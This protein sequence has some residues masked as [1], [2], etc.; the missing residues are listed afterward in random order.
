GRVAVLGD[1]HDEL[2][3]LGRAA[4]Q[5]PGDLQPP[6]ADY[7]CL[8][9]Q[10]PRPARMLPAAEDFGHHQAMPKVAC[11]TSSGLRPQPWMSDA[12]L[13]MTQPGTPR[14]GSLTCSIVSPRMGV[15]S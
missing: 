11:S 7:G 10:I 3:A 1:L 6:P 8:S 14:L 13:K 5:R 9:P 2:A 15:R 12:R 4:G